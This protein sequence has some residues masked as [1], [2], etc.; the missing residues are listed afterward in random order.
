MESPN[1]GISRAMRCTNSL[2][3]DP[4]RSL[5]EQ[6]QVYKDAVNGHLNVLLFPSDGTETHNAYLRDTLETYLSSFIN[7]RLVGL[8]NFNGHAT[9]LSIVDPPRKVRGLDRLRRQLDFNPVYPAEPLNAQYEYARS[10]SFRGSAFQSYIFSTLLNAIAASHISIEALETCGGMMVDDALTVS[11]AEEQALKPIFQKLQYLSACISSAHT[12]EKERESLD[13]DER[14]L[15]SVLEKSVIWKERKT[16]QKERKNRLLP[17]LALAAPSL[18]SLNL[19]MR[20]ASLLETSLTWEKSGLDLV[21]QHF[22]WISEHFHFSQLSSLSLSHLMV[23]LPSFSRMLHTT[24]S[25]LKDLKL[26]WLIW[27]SELK[28]PASGYA[29]GEHREVGLRVIRDACDYIRDNFDLEYLQISQWQYQREKFHLRDPYHIEGGSRRRDSSSR[30]AT[31]N[32]TRD[33]ISS[34]QWIDQVEF[35]KR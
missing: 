11:P 21:D 22:E 10:S 28:I 12:Q 29:R 27:T 15:G 24:S 1:T 31:Y 30:T 20:L 23:T 32:R 17:L 35:V 5:E 18:K 25:T 9:R 7:L 2:P 19:T 14:E 4:R 34:G 6:H 13:Q 26:A 3:G 33:A 8:R 16:L